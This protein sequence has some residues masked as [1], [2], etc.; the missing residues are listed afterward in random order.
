MPPLFNGLNVCQP[1]L[2]SSRWSYWEG[3]GSELGDPLA[4]EENLAKLETL[5]TTANIVSCVL[6]TARV[7]GEIKTALRLLGRPLPENDVWIAAVA[8]QHRLTL[9][10]RDAHFEQVAGLDRDPW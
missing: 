5:A 8:I 2:S 3:C 9:V 10:T 4:Y 6:A 7:Y 1:R